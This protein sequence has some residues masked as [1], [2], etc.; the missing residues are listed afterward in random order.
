MMIPATTLVRQKWDFVRRGGERIGTLQFAADG[1]VIGQTSPFEQHWSLTQDQL[2]LSGDGGLATTCFHTAMLAHGRWMLLGDFLPLGWPD[3]HELHEGERVED[4]ES[5]RDTV[6][7]I[8]SV[9]HEAVLFRTSSRVIAALT[10]LGIYFGR[11]V[12]RFAEGDV[13]FVP[14]AG[15]TEPYCSYS[16]GNRI[17][18]MG[19]FSYTESPL[20]DMRIGRYCSIASGLDVF[21]DRHPVEW[22]T[23]SSISYDFIAPIGYQAFIAAQEHFNQGRMPPRRPDTLMAPP[24]TLEHDIWIGQNVQLARGITIGTGSVIAAGAV[25]TRDVPPY[26]IMGGVPARKIKQRFSDR[27][28]ERMLGTRWWR[29]G[30][31]L[32]QAA[33]ITDPERFVDTA[34]AWSERAPFEPRFIWAEDL[35][36]KLA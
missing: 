35:I 30:P 17:V 4:W 19:A 5:V 23:S 25:V 32:L 21:K 31:D 26:S 14:R 1:R 3:H 24:P 34:D 12:N 2:V 10:G 9:F 16:I 11:S 8:L 27:V 13:V 36:A 20:P 7:E 28:V 29:H 33:D 15:R 22:A 6:P 18:E